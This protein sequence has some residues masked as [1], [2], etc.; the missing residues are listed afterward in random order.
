MATRGITIPLRLKLLDGRNVP[1]DVDQELTVYELKTHIGSLTGIPISVQALIFEGQQMEDAMI[2][3]EV[4]VMKDDVITVNVSDEQRASATLNER[5]VG[6]GS[7]ELSTAAL[8]GDTEVVEL[9]LTSGV[10]PNSIDM[11]GNTCLMHAASHCNLVVMQILI[12]SGADVNARGCSEETA[13]MW[14]SSHGHEEAISFLID[15]GADPTHADADGD[16]ALMWAASH[17]H[18][19]CVRLLSLH[20]DVSIANTEGLTALD[21]AR[22]ENFDEIVSFFESL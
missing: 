4:G 16:N 18:L 13:I 10:S 1:L 14:A 22:D 9:L 3:V 8:E 2:L 11:E 6:Q 21:Q 12:S 20:S 19:K 7:L 15:A 5:G 17:G